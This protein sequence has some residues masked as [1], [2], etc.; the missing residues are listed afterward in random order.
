L[1]LAEIKLSTH[2]KV[3]RNKSKDKHN[4]SKD[5]HNKSKDKHNKSKDKHK[6]GCLQI[7]HKRD[8]ETSS[9]Q[10]YY[11]PSQYVH[12]ML[13]YRGNKY[14]SEARQ[15]NKCSKRVDMNSISKSDSKLY[16]SVPNISGD[17]AMTHHKQSF[18]KLPMKFESNVNYEVL[19][20]Y[21]SKNKKNKRKEI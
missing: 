19:M 11:K 17:V 21:K 10:S 1:P 14:I 2:S 15:I 4:K 12:L 16:L 18:H 20:Q 6:Y 5:K 8:K 9:S 7:R 13:F 3:K